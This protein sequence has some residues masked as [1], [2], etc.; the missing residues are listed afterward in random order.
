MMSFVLNKMWD[1][2]NFLK[3]NVHCKFLTPYTEINTHIQWHTVPFPPQLEL[4]VP[5]YCTYSMRIKSCSL[6]EVQGINADGTPILDPSKDS[7]AF[8][9]AMSK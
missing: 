1:D 3:N 6:K 9:E 5:Q 8:Q 7:D 2:L 4:E